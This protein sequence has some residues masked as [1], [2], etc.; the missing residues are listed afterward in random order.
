MTATRANNEAPSIDRQ[1]SP[2]F[3]VEELPG[4]I[5]TLIVGDGAPLVLFP[6]LSRD[7]RALTPKS[8]AKIAWAYRGLATVTRRSVYVVHRP[9]GLSPAVTMPD[10]A[11]SHAVALRSLFAEAVDVMGISTGGGIALQ[12]AVDHPQIVRR[13]IVA[14]AASSLGDV[15][16]E[17]LAQYGTLV[18]QGKNGAR[19]LAK[20]LSPPLLRWPARLAIWFSEWLERSID[21]ADMLA[22]IHAECGFDVTDRLGEIRVPTL[23]IAGEKDRAF[24]PEQFRVTARGIPGAKLVLYPNRGHITAMWDPRFGRDIAAFLQA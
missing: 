20:V 10:L 15:G 16:R 23:I 17:R 6:G 3:R 4:N 11:T 2:S 9:R 13:L 14:G 18:R 19:I 7:S 24:S 1:P 22:T 12:L 5:S 8:A 21:P